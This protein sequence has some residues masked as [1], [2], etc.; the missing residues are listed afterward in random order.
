MKA[1]ILAA[2]RGMRMLP[3][4][5]RIPKVLVTVNGRPFLS[6]VLENLRSAGYDEFGIV[7]G[8]KKEMVKEY[9]EANGIKATLIDQEE[10][11]GTGHAVLQ[12]KD[13]VGDD[14]FVILGGDN[15][16]SV[17]DLK[18]VRNHDE[19]CYIVGKEIDDPRKYGVLIVEED[20]LV[21]IVEKPQ[22][23]V[24]NMINIGLYKFTPEIWGAL[25]KIEL[26]ERGEYELTDALTL[27][28]QEGKVKVLKMKGYWLDLGSND[29]IEPISSF[30]REKHS[31]TKPI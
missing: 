1:V 11:K 30:L 5:E 20:K 8:Y 4:T 25:D 9:I 6:Y 28:A 3:L 27:L 12:A 22:V 14:D 17:Y 23:Y 19:Y 31:P 18:S 2:G 24:G 26:S 15:L 13:F 16:F 10:Q 7:V 29:D 21:K